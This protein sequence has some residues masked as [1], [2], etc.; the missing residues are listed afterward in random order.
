MGPRDQ[1]WGSHASGAAGCCEPP[2]FCP[3]RRRRCSSGPL[4]TRLGKRRGT[5]ASPT[6]PAPRRLQKSTLRTSRHVIT[7][8]LLYPRG[9]PPAL[10]S[11]FPP[12]SVPVSQTAVAGSGPTATQNP[13]LTRGELRGCAVRGLGLPRVVPAARPDKG[14]CL[15]SRCLMAKDSG[16][17]LPLPLA[18]FL[19]GQDVGW[20]LALLLSCVPSASP[21]F[22]V[23]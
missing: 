7:S 16:W 23:K 9:P 6:L 13:G 3:G 20:V 4:G 10:P 22:F 8:P 15:C 19:E 17:C 2:A 21:V 1:L 12:S 11:S 5:S 14:R 18:S